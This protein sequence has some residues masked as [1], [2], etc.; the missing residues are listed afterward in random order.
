MGGID[1]VSSGFV[2]AYEFTRRA[3][4]LFEESK[5]RLLPF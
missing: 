3:F 5:L 4:E 1:T 2:E